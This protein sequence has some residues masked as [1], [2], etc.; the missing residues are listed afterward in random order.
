[1]VNPSKI[2]L[3]FFDTSTLFAALT[4]EHPQH[5]W[6]RAQRV[7][8][9]QVGLSTHTLAETYKVLTMHPHVRLPAA[10]ALALLRAVRQSSLT[11]SL[12]DT[13]YFAALE[14]CKQQHL[15][16]SV[17]F[18]ALIAQAALKAGAG[19]LVTLNSKDFL[20]LGED[21]AALVVS[22]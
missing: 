16:G 13:D 1:M 8:A 5:A 14:R 4:A 6:A 12:N 3:T 2:V 10:E 19:S 7:R 9:E 11:I 20:R 18:D 21:I 17:I 15:S 22:P